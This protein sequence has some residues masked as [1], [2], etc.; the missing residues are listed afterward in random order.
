LDAI[1]KK[2]RAKG[3]AEICS[4]ELF[5]PEYWELEPETVI[6]TAAEKTKRFL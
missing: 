5:R 1:A 4:V 3:Y 6:K 2:L